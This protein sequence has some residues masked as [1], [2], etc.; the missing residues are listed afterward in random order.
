MVLLL[1]WF[2]AAFVL[3][4]RSIFL[5]GTTSNGHVYCLSRVVVLAMKD[6]NL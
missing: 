5:P 2:T 3:D 1:V 4:Q 6:L